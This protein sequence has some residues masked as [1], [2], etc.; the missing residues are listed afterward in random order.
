MVTMI[1]PA[2]APESFTDAVL[3]TI[4]EATWPDGSPM[5]DVDP[6]VLREYLGPRLLA[7]AA[8]FAA[9][10]ALTRQLEEGRS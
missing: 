3:A 4:T 7:V 1:P 6:G 2:Q 8:S 5:V 10:V 9:A